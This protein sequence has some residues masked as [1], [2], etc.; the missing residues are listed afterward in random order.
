MSCYPLLLRLNDTALRRLHT[1]LPFV[2]GIVSLRHD[3]KPEINPLV[4]S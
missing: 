4:N 2:Y 3:A 1:I